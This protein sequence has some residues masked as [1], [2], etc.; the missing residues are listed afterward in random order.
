MFLL[1]GFFRIFYEAPIKIFF[2]FL[3][4]L[5]FNLKKSLVDAQARGTNCQKIS[6]PSS[7][8]RRQIA[9]CAVF[10]V[11]IMLISFSPARYLPEAKNCQEK[12][13][14]CK[15]GNKLFSGHWPQQK[16]FL[17]FFAITFFFMQMLLSVFIRYYPTMRLFFVFM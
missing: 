4:I 5:I 1:C 6:T 2:K 17:N 8:S 10:A 3:N 15:T 13:E 11:I 12:I 16:L 9:S 14:I 7:S